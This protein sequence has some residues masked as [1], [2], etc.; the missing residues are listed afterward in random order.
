[1][2]QYFFINE[3][4]T[5]IF[6]V[7][8]DDAIYLFNPAVK[9]WVDA[10]WLLDYF[11]DNEDDISPIAERNLQEA[12]GTKSLLTFAPEQLSE[13]GSVGTHSEAKE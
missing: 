13:L 10:P 7:K 8:V 3:K 6:L 9:E 12:Y 1:M 11:Y 5:P 4:T 2:A